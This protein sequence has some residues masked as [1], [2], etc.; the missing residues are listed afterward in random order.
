M[1][2]YRHTQPGYLILVTVGLALAWVLFLMVQIDF[3][4]IT[5]FLSVVLLAA[6]V[7]FSSLTV[8]VDDSALVV[9]F[10]PGVARRVFP[11]RSIES[12][13]TVYN[14]WYAGWGIRW[15]PW[16]SVV[17][18]VSGTAGVELR[19]TTGGRFRIGSDQPDAL[20]QALAARDVEW[21]R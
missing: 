4:P 12:V 5:V 14:P 1:L 7:S 18:N 17:Y 21:H 9:W 10:G 16:L 8:Q 6:L 20:A 11:L 3:H 15:V 19:L 13:R 2:V